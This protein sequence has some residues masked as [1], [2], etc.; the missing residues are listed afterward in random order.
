MQCCN[1]EFDVFG[2]SGGSEL[3]SFAGFTV[4]TW[5]LTYKIKV[6]AKFT[7]S[8]FWGL[9]ENCEILVFIVKSNRIWLA[10]G[11]IGSRLHKTYKTLPNHVK[12]NT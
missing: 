7:F 4:F 10:F 5:F 2:V 12:N 6:F 11:E 8:W 3:C 1:S 9:V